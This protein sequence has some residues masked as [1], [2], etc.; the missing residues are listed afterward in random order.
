MSDMNN[1]LDEIHTSGS[2]GEKA[3]IFHSGKGNV[4][5]C[6]GPALIPL[7]APLLTPNAQKN[8]TALCCKGNRYDKFF[9]LRLLSMKPVCL[10]DSN[11]INEIALKL[12]GVF[13]SLLPTTWAALQKNSTLFVLAAVR[14][15]DLFESCSVDFVPVNTIGSTRIQL[16]MKC[17]VLFQQ[18]S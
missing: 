15:R 12:K 11:K 17:N 13:S 18:S 10:W 6:P 9:S 2:L 5:G 7:R 4:S 14:H 1:T 16:S 8:R 3:D